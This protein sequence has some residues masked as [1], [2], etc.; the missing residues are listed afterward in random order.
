VTVL[1]GFDGLRGLES[2][3]LTVG[4]GALVE[5]DSCSRDGAGRRRGLTKESLE[6]CCRFSLDGTGR[7]PARTGS[8]ELEGRGSLEELVDGSMIAIVHANAGR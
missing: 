4:I 1:A 3:G 6:E 7:K 5:P 8:L 2:R